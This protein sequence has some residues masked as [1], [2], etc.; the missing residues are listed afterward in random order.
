VEKEVSEPRF[1]L[2]TTSLLSSHFSFYLP[3]SVRAEEL[4]QYLKKFITEEEQG[5]HI[6]EHFAELFGL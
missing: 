2:A 6:G 1:F 4:E 5:P 3:E